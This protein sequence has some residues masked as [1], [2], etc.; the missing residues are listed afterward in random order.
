MTVAG[1]INKDTKY[2][3]FKMVPNENR[4]SVCLELI[5]KFRNLEKT[6]LCTDYHVIYRHYKD[7]DAVLLN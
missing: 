4:E 2:S 3:I 6:N 1:V 5:D 7:D